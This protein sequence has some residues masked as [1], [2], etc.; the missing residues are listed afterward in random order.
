MK[1]LACAGGSADPLILDA[2]L[3]SDPSG[4]PLKKV[5]WRVAPDSPNN[6]SMLAA[7]LAAVN[8][9]K[10]VRGQAVVAIS[11]AE[12]AALYANTTGSPK[13]F[14]V[15]AAVT[16]AFGDSAD[17]VATFTLNAA[18]ATPSVRI[19][20]PQ[21]ARRFKIKDG[22][23]VAAAVDSAS[24]CDAL[25][26]I[27]TWSP[28]MSDGATPWASSQLTATGATAVAPGPVPGVADGNQFVVRLSA[29]NPNSVGAAAVASVGLIAEAAGLVAALDGPSSVAADKAIVL[30]AA[31]SYDPDGEERKRGWAVRKG[32][33]QRDG[34]KREE[35]RQGVA[36]DRGQ[37]RLLSPML[38]KLPHPH[39]N[40]R[41]NHI[42]TA[43]R[44]Q[45][46]PMSVEPLRFEWA[47]ARAD[48]KPCF[49]T[50]DA[51]GDQA[52]AVWAIPA[53]GLQAGV[54]HTFTVTVS[55]GARSAS[56]TLPEL[57]VVA[58][59]TPTGR[60]E[61]AC[62]GGACAARHAGS[63]DLVVVL[64]DAPAKA[65]VA[66]SLNGVAVDGASGAKA[67]IPA[68]SLPI[69]GSPA[70]VKA[71]LA[72]GDAKGEAS[73]TVPINAAPRCGA[74]S[75]KCLAV[76]KVDD[77][78]LGAE[79]RAELAELRDDGAAS[80]VTYEWTLVGADGAVAPLRSE[81]GNAFTLRGLAAGDSTLTV[82]AVDALGASYTESAT[83]TVKPFAGNVTAASVA[84][85]AALERA[86]NSRDSAAIAAAARQVA[87]L[88]R[89]HGAATAAAK[90]ANANVTD[91]DPAVTAALDGR[92]RSLFTAAGDL[93]NVF[94]APGAAV[95]AAAAA[96][97]FE[98]T[99]NRTAV[100]A[101][102]AIDIADT[103][104]RPLSLA[105][106][107]SP[108]A[109]AASAAAAAAAAEQQQQQQSSNSSSSCVCD[110]IVPQIGRSP[111]SMSLYPP[112]SKAAF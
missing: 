36:E 88:N 44:H 70:V 37:E 14:K 72:V 49:S 82:R 58:A 28:L 85:N 68:A 99:F 94:D 31:N 89:L 26:A 38:I 57:R 90:A 51:R 29:A 2:S 32:Q 41:T 47:C 33:R 111:P 11:A 43:H 77:S 35:R 84:S 46:D 79:F 107:V 92:A 3:S 17:A 109:A 16:G 67:I 80:D 97:A 61:R 15:S 7:M 75:G 62:V 25:P 1:S 103:G 95:W 71:A 81:R 108:A 20:G 54:K 74:A 100:D 48:S 87:A 9:L 93:I 22:F 6:S 13:T 112:L 96:D 19:L 73:L 102:N 21:A 53:G 86:A 63:D 78:L 66:W 27:Y 101:Q 4:R 39:T 18:G 106:R 60:L 91:A 12:I 69:D 24:V 55:K 64:T 59:G 30:S 5:E 76:T 52:G 110:V 45:T 8:A 104:E 56:A 40:A 105:C 65:A 23:R 42:I 98:A 34:S 10:T 83:V 50:L